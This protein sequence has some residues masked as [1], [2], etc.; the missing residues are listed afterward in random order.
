[1][2]R[3]H[4]PVVTETGRE[5]RMVHMSLCTLP[6]HVYSKQCRHA[7]TQIHTHCTHKSQGSRSQESFCSTKEKEGILISHW[8]KTNKILFEKPQ[9]QNESKFSFFLKSNNKY[10][11]GNHFMT[12]KWLNNYYLKTANWFRKLNWPNLLQQ[13]SRWIMLSQFPAAAK[14]GTAAGQWCQTDSGVL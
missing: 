10:C 7:I 13:V 9:E 11:N 6:M 14:A 3:T 4:D 5:L 2:D 12:G 8:L 1:M